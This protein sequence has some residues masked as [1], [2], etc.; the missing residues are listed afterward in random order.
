MMITFKMLIIIVI[1]ISHVDIRSKPMAI[2]LYDDFRV[3]FCYVR[4]GLS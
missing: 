1:I 3:C 4:T 2:L